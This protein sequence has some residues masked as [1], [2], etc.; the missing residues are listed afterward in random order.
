MASTG[1]PKKFDTI[2][3]YTIILSNINR[4]LKLFHC[5]NQEKICNNSVTKD[6]T[7]SSVSTLPYEM[8]L[9]GASYHSISLIMP[10]VSDVAGLKVK[11]N[12]AIFLGHPVHRFLFA[13]IFRIMIS[14]FFWFYS[15]D[16]ADCSA[17]F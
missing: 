5:Q 9:S 7:T 14:A 13:Y 17:A 11:A 12:C 3:L 8:S 15:A 2:F 6:P 4:F 16:S 1:S 10:L